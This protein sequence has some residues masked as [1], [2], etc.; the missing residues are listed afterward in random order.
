[1]PAV[2]LFEGKLDDARKAAD[3]WYAAAPRE[4]ASFARVML[5]VIDRGLG[6]EG[7][8]DKVGAGCVPSPTWKK[9]NPDG[10]PGDYCR[11]ATAVLVPDLLT[12]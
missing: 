5:S 10:D 1:M 7:A 9:E 3:D 6:R 12:V 8:L 2:L 11:E 4:R